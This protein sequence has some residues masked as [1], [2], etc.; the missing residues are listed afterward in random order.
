MTDKKTSADFRNYNLDNCHF[1]PLSKSVEIYVSG[2]HKFGTDAFLLSDFAA[3]RRK[4]KVC[5][6]GTGCGIIPML[7]FRHPEN[8]PKEAWGVDIQPKAIEQLKISVE[9]NGLSAVFFPVCADLKELSG[10]VPFDSFDIVT[11]NPPYKAAG[12]GIL[13]ETDAHTIARHEVMCNID[14]VCRAASKLLKFGGK[15]CICQRPERLLDVMQSMREN[16]IEPKRVR[17][18]HQRPDEAPWL[19][20][21]EGKKGAKPFL[22]VEKPFLI[23]RIED[24]SFSDELLKI[25]GYD[26]PIMPDKGEN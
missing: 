16:K 9:K 3:Y 14:D 4:D 24:R 7:M 8:T 19:V 10:K 23:E 15:L 12:Q 25:Y 18:V 5:D 22:K 1:E 17:M 13:N 21:I 6:L 2:E 20:L 11:C 26:S